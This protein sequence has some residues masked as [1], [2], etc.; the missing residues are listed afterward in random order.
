MFYFLQKRA[1]KRVVKTADKIITELE[2]VYLDLDYF[3]RDDI[4]IIELMQWTEDKLDAMA[5]VI[6]PNEDFIIEHHPELITRANR[7]SHIA[8]KCGE[9]GVKEF[10]DELAGLGNILA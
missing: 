4:N 1:K 3:T 10:Q 8:L 7:V 9:T 6:E 2:S 5:A